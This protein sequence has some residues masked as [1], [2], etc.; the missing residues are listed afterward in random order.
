[1]KEGKEEEGEGGA[2][3]ER[4]G[5][6]LAD[7]RILGWVG[8]ARPSGRISTSSTS[9]TSSINNNGSSTSSG[10]TSNSYHRPRWWSVRS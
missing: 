10:S 5:W 1:V 2:E 6:F 8:L 9:S 7:G 4:E 3:V